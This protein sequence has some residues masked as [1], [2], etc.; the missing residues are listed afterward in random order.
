MYILTFNTRYS[1]RVTQ[2]TDTTT[3]YQLAP[4]HCPTRAWH[5]G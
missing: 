3:D 5:P 4:W 2:P 1:V